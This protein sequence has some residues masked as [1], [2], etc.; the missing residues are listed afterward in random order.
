MEL[1]RKLGMRTMDVPVLLIVFNRLDAAKRTFEAIRAA[2]PARLY[3]AA[4]GPR[5]DRAG[6]AD[7]CAAVR[8]W[9][10]SQ[11]D[12]DCAVK[13]RFLDENIGCGL[14]PST[15]IS[16]M[17]E[18][19][20]SGI[21]IE[22]DCVPHPDFFP[23]AGEMLEKY[24]GNRD[25]MAVNSSN[26]Q[27][28]PRGDGSY[29]FSMQNGPFCAWATW[30]RAWEAFD[31]TMAKYPRAMITSAL[32]R[33]Y[34]VTRR[35]KKWWMDIYDGLLADRYHGSSWDYQFIFAIW[36]NHGK[37]VVPN[38]NLSTNIGFGPEATHTMDA[39]SVTANRPMQP[40]LPLTFPSSED[41]NRQA[42]LFYH[43]FYYDRFVDH[44]PLWKK[45][46]WRIKSLIKR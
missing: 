21:I 35:E 45:L 31:F 36:A 27:P 18:S 4:D 24:A 6:E 46:K 42:D 28:V 1:E 5:K 23:Y 11:I 7:R 38:A 30:K 15:A 8:E 40:L 44:T 12:W 13:T 41:I 3:V 14:G 37:S 29:Y 10:M 19:E 26:F 17:F 22:D 39:N 32:G 9:I 25:V 33:F 34:R 20:E 2:R 43:D 16:W